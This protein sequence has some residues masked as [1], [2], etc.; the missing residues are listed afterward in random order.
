MCFAQDILKFIYVALEHCP[1]SRPN[2]MH[3]LR[4]GQFIGEICPSVVTTNF[5]E[6]QLLELSSK[7]LQTWWRHVMSQPMYRTIQL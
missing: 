3:M 5:S 7:F 2:P 1:P 6:L 4:S